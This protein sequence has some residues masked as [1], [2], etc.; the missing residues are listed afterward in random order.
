MKKETQRWRSTKK[1]KTFIL[2]F[3]ECSLVTCYANSAPLFEWFISVKRK[4]VRE[5]QH[6]SVQLKSREKPVFLLQISIVEI[7]FQMTKLR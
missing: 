4:R 7:H 3:L 1:K 2:C 6:R 5:C